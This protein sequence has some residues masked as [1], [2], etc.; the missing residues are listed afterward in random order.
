MSVP[1]PAWQLSWGILT[2][3]TAQAAAVSWA[4]RVLMTST[5]AA[6]AAAYKAAQVRHCLP[7]VSTVFL[8]KTVPFHA[9]PRAAQVEKVGLAVE[10]QV[11]R[12][13]AT[14]AWAGWRVEKRLCLHWCK[15][16]WEAWKVYL[17]MQ[18]LGAYGN[19]QTLVFLP[20]STS[21]VPLV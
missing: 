11:Q 15:R 1:L 6:F 13:L 12:R 18:Q 8:S 20:V 5:L 9:V 14:A 3:G 21:A 10:R 19:K 17:G 2:Q 4:D 16:Y 7:V